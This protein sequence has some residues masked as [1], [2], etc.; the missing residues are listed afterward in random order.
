MLLLSV[1]VFA[2]N[3][4]WKPVHSNEVASF[5]NGKDVF[6]GKFKPVTFKLFSL[7]EDVFGNLLKQAQLSKNISLQ[8]G[9][10][11]SVPVADG[12]IE[13][14][15]IAESPVMSEKLQ[16]KFPDIRSYV[17]QGIDDPYA[18]INVILIVAGYT[19]G[20]LLG[21]FLF[22]IFTKRIL[23]QNAIMV[24][25]CIA[26]PVISYVLSTHA[27]QWF[28]GYTI[29]IE[30]LLINGLLTFAGLLLVSKSAQPNAMD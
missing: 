26:A 19:Y 28:N 12:S 1:S 5:T 4:Y 6:P 29:G 2:Q 13:R 8:S 14:F 7:Q 3:N 22:G 25:I 20:P 17:G 11:I 30:L 15:R 21:L 24:L 18:I 10:L 27:T 23:P 16:A 9:L